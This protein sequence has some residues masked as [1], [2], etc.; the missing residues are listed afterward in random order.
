MKLI[1]KDLLL[2]YGFIQDKTKSKNGLTVLTKAKVD[3]IIKNDGTVWYSNLG[4]DY[5]LKDLS[6]LRKLYKEI[7]NTELKP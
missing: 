3:I 1:N 7:R 4:I 2:E 5:P 6:A